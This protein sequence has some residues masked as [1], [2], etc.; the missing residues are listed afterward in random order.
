[1][2]KINLPDRTPRS[3]PQTTTG[4]N[5]YPIGIVIPTYNR[6]ENLITCLQHLERQTFKDFEVIIVDDGSSDGTR[7]TMEKYLKTSPFPCRYVY[8]P[9]SG[10]ARARNQAIQLLDSKVCLLLGDDIFALPDLVRVHLDHHLLHTEEEAA[11]IGLIQWSRNGQKVTQFMRW[12]D[13]GRQFSYNDLFR[14]VAPSWKHFYT[15][16]LSLKT[17]Q[18][19]RYPF[20]ERF[21]KAAMEDI[22]LGYRL[23]MHQALRMTFL[24]TAIGEHF[25]PTSFRQACR[26]MIGVGS[27]AYL[28]G[29]IWPEHRPRPLS[30]RKKKIVHLLLKH[31]WMVP[32]LASVADLAVRL[33]GPNKLTE[34]ALTLHSCLGHEQAAAHGGMPAKK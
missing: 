10:P 26:R 33:C 15:S 13:D 9:N 18:L 3:E 30:P 23:A 2:E 28:F 21:R 29:E 25:H 24:P 31:P 6:I 20:D 27:S 34:K 16:N 32:C 19:R 1:M 14:G 4:T 11:A 7:P 17:G 22:E 5:T 8:Q 12:L